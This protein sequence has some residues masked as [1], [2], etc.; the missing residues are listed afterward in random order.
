MSKNTHDLEEFDFDDFGFDDNSDFGVPEPKVDRKPVVRGAGIAKE[1]AKQ[2]VGEK[3][4]IRDAMRAALPKGYLEAFDVTDK[5]SRNARSLYNEVLTEIAPGV[6]DFKKATKALLPKVEGIIPKKFA[7]KLRGWSSTDDEYQS[8]SKAQADGEELN[9]TLSDIFEQKAS[10]DEALL[11][12]QTAQNILLDRKEERRTNKQLQIL[13]GIQ[14]LQA[15]VVGYQDSVLAKYQR[16]SL[17]LQYRHYFAARDLLEV[18]RA[19]N[20]TIVRNLNDVVKNTALPDYLKINL[21]EDARRFMRDRMFGKVAE[22]Y[23]TW[24]QQFGT[25]MMEKLRAKGKEHSQN[26]NSAAS[27]LRD[28]GDAAG[29]VD[30]LGKNER[31]QLKDQGIASGLSFLFSATGMGEALGKR[32]EAKIPE[33]HKSAIERLGAKLGYAANNWQGML[34]NWAGTGTDWNNPFAF[35]IDSAKDSINKFGGLDARVDQI[36]ALNDHKPTPFDG[37]AHRSLTEI[38]PGFLSRILQSTEGLRTG[39]ETPRLVYNYDRGEFTTEHKAAKDA[40]E[41]IVG[42]KRALFNQG[43]DEVVNNIDEEQKLSP[44]ARQLLRDNVVNDTRKGGVGFTPEAYAKLDKYKGVDPEV[45]KE[46]VQHI[47]QTYGV[48]EPTPVAGGVF[49]DLDEGVVGGTL[50]RLKEV[51]NETTAQL[52]GTK[53]QLDRKNRDVRSFQEMRAFAPE[54]G[55]SFGGY[56]NS[57]NRDLLRLLGLLKKEGTTDVVDNELLWR[58]LGEA[59]SEPLADLEEDENGKGNKGNRKRR[60]P[61]RTPPR[62]S[63]RSD[64]G[65]DLRDPRPVPQ[66]G[67]SPLEWGTELEKRLRVV[68]QEQTDSLIKAIKDEPKVDEFENT[69]KLLAQLVEYAE[70][71]DKKINAPTQEVPPTSDGSQ[72]EPVPPEEG[73]RSWWDVRKWG[74]MGWNA[75]KWAGKKAWKLYTAPLR[76]TATATRFGW[77]QLKALGGFGKEKIDAAA[78][79]VYVKGGHVPLITRKGIIAGDYTD[80]NTGKVITAFADITG[81]VVDREGNQVITQADIDAG[82]VNAK[83]KTIWVK[84]K[85]AGGMLGRGLGSLAKGYLNL[86]LLPAK[87]AFKAAKKVH[88]ISKNWYDIYVEGE[89]VPRITAAKLRAGEYV[90]S[91]TGK[92]IKSWKDIDGDIHDKFGNVVLSKEDAK[93]VC[94]RYGR[95]IKSLITRALTWGVAKAWGAAKLAARGAMWAGKKAV[96]LATA[97]LRL[98]GKMLKGMYNYGFGVHFNGQTKT[99][100]ELL[101]MIYE[102]LDKRLTKRKGKVSGDSDGDGNRDNDWRDIVK[103]RREKANKKPPKL[104]ANGKP[105]PEKSTGLFGKLLLLVG[106]I[107]TGIHKVIDKVTDV[108]TW[109]KKGFTLVGEY[110][111]KKKA[112]DAAGDLLGGA[113]DLPGGRRGKKGLIK[114]AG[115]WV[116]RN[117]TKVWTGVRTAGTIAATAAPVALGGLAAAGGALASGAAT[118]GGWALGA[119]STIGSVLLSPWV[120]AGAAVA[121]VGYGA[122]KFYRRLGDLGYLRMAQYGFIE[123]TD[124]DSISKIRWLEDKLEDHVLFGQDGRPKL[125]D[126]VPWDE[127]LTEFGY[128]QDNHEGIEALQ[129]WMQSRFAPVYLAHRQYQSVYDKSKSLATI[130]RMDDD[131][132]AKIAKAVVAAIGKRV[133]SISANPFRGDPLETNEAEIEKRLTAITGKVKESGTT[134]TTT[135]TIA[136][137]VL[138]G[139]QTPYTPTNISGGIHANLAAGRKPS[140]VTTAATAGVTAASKA[141]AGPTEQA[142]KQSKPVTASAVNSSDVYYLD[143]AQVDRS[144][145][146]AIKAGKFI[147]TEA[148]AKS[149]DALASVRFRAYGLDRLDVNDIAVLAGLEQ[150]VAQHIAT[151]F[152]GGASVN[153][154]P[155]EYYSKY[156]AS[157]GCTVD[158]AEQR[159]RWVFWFKNRFSPV[160]LTLTEAL[161][162]TGRQVDIQTAWRRLSAADLLKVCQAVISA[163]SEVNGRSASVWSLNVSPF[164]N[165]EVNTDAGSCDVTVE[166][167]K[168]K[169]KDAE[170]VEQAEKAKRKAAGFTDRAMQDKGSVYPGAPAYSA[171]GYGPQAGGATRYDYATGRWVPLGNTPTT[172][173]ADAAYTPMEG[174]EHPGNGTG[175]DINSLP[176]PKGDGAPNVLP[177]LLAVAKM[178]GVDPHLLATM[179]AVESDFVVSAKAGTSSAGGL[180]QFINSTWKGMVEKYGSKYGIAPNTPKEDPRANALLGAEYIRE[181][182]EYLSKAIGRKPNAND[183]YMAHFLGPAGA[184]QILTGNPNDI[185]ARL[186]PKAAAA[187]ASVFY[188][189]NGKGA[190]RTVRALQAEIARRMSSRVKRYGLDKVDGS[191]LKT[192]DFKITATDTTTQTEKTTLAAGAGTT[193]SKGGLNDLKAKEA[194][195]SKTKPT[196]KAPLS[197][198]GLN[199]SGGANANTTK[200]VA[201]APAAMAVAANNK[202]QTAQVNNAEQEAAAR[203]AQLRAQQEQVSKQQSQADAVSSELSNKQLERLT[204]IDNTLKRILELTATQ[205]PV[206]VEGGAESSSNVNAPVNS[207]KLNPDLRKSPVAMGGY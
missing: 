22:N 60:P 18:Q 104:D 47:I 192:T 4:N 174:Y 70:S 102:L 72:G 38:I 14:E 189:N 34:Q 7:E 115:K 97:P 6:R 132:R 91:K 111:A 116:A 86:Y 48:R 10:A 32:I 185:A 140:I 109:L 188:E 197:N 92:V 19:S 42:N 31:D 165:R 81:P 124:D 146:E 178:V 80:V 135:A 79:D 131:V 8:Y 153:V 168:S 127:I 205:K 85:K 128:T 112:I 113:D 98:G 117:A 151:G 107:G 182:Y 27:S 158:N 195:L 25:G 56:A 89:A 163:N 106:A 187:N 118:V 51:A 120:L 201:A 84:L 207:R 157:F 154:D 203:R 100:T 186:N 24:A 175:G 122:Y 57:G 204:S 139:T 138:T 105:V 152:F 43:V 65:S 99:Q 199:G 198:P 179:C 36:S 160:L 196:A 93:K 13:T 33:K 108:G 147:W 67:P 159:D 167:L 71:I 130:D 37:R 30:G 134:T 61:R 68:V 126:K 75:S 76:A 183:L 28:L 3:Q 129:T 190:P 41:K 54:V 82:L 73:K 166:W 150:D 114:R 164:P 121:G 45:A 62:G 119:A 35:A 46:L 26:F 12:Q 172:A 64:R 133:L 11:E 53:E 16:K 137:G 50:R 143:A 63:N 2:I 184:K 87:L 59:G 15:R 161:K 1:A 136:G 194:S 145:V 90:S 88:D 170:V 83:G 125:G 69:N 77:K 23:G 171:V 149:L 20:E 141:N 5:A 103:T 95:P 162:R 44:K 58:Y 142:N 66:S 110:F 96:K 101:G 29:M 148:S 156:A 39:K 206:I 49:D 176:T 40:F 155:V 173:A 123:D 169:V 74:K 193:S 177:L 202:T 180:F 181:N 191:D 9:S 52:A 21:T 144:K 78:F 17:E 55:K 200:P 94:D